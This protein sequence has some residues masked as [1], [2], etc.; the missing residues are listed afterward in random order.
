MSSFWGGL[1]Q[2]Y[3]YP[4]GI[5][6]AVVTLVVF[7]RWL[8]RDAS[9]GA[10]ADA[11]APSVG[12]GMAFGRI[13]C[14]SYGCCFGTISHLPWVVQFPAKSPAWQAHVIAGLVPADASTSLPVHPL[15]LYLLVLALSGTALALVLRSRSVLPGLAALTFMFIDQLG[16]FGLEFLR[17]H[18]SLTLQGSSLGIALFA[19]IALWA[20]RFRGNHPA[21]HYTDR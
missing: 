14:F 21:I 13:G 12:I 10:M 3:R 15:Q 9:I 7:R 1:T 16:K 17:D 4:G 18:Q 8:F 20:L 6:A 11:L 2:G 5:I 19:A